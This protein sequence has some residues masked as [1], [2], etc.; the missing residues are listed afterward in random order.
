[1]AIK[2]VN[3]QDNLDGFSN[4]VG[5]PSTGQARASLYTDGSYS[6]EKKQAGFGAYLQFEGQ[7][8]SWGGEIE[9]DN[10]SLRYEHEAMLNGLKLAKSVGAAA[11]DIYIDCKSLY[12]ELIAR[13]TEWAC[14]VSKLLDQCTIYLIYSHVGIYGSEFADSLSRMY[15][16]GLPKEGFHL[17]A[18]DYRFFKVPRVALNFNELLNRI[19]KRKKSSENAVNTT[20]ANIRKE[21]TQKNHASPPTVTKAKIENNSPTVVK[22]NSEKAQKVILFN[23]SFENTN[24]NQNQKLIKCTKASPQKTCEKKQTPIKKKNPKAI[25]VRADKNKPA[26]VILVHPVTKK[27]FWVKKTMYDQVKNQIL[28]QRK[29]EGIN[30]NRVSDAH[31]AHE[32]YKQQCVKEKEKKKAA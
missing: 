28:T 30:K 6:Y 8:F 25:V 29:E 31:V 15:L 16:D 20:Q 17:Q 11:L 22:A 12:Q 2:F 9:G 24:Q 14:E 7:F 27:R 4:L 3:L 1:M 5:F 26:M 23:K 13:S 10:I 32:I 18:N 21:T 19:K